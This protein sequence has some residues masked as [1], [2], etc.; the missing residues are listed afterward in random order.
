MSLLM[1]A[2]CPGCGLVFQKNLRNLCMDCMKSLDNEFDACIKYLRIHRKATTE[3]LSESSGA[4]EKR[5]ITWIKERRLSITDYP[6]LTYPCNSCG[7]PINQQDICF[8]CRTRLTRDIREM[9]EKEAKQTSQG[10]G[11]RSRIQRG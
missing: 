10:F 7:G 5:I 9:R 1:V 3:E 6:N 4:P 2:N 8:S 11:F